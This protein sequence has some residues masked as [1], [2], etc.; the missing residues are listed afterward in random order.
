MWE[1]ELTLGSCHVLCRRATSALGWCC[2]P[3]SSGRCPPSC[4]PRPPRP[5]RATWSCPRRPCRG[6]RRPGVEKAPGVASSTAPPDSLETHSLLSSHVT[7][8]PQL[9]IHLS[10]SGLFLPIL[11]TY[12][13]LFNPLP[14][15]TSQVAAQ[16]VRPG[17]QVVRVK[18]E[19]GWEEVGHRPQTHTE[20]RRLCAPPGGELGNLT[21]TSV[22][23][24]CCTTAK[25]RRTQQT[26]KEK[27]TQ[28]RI[29]LKRKET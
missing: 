22:D 23:E 26:H 3:W 16:L 10:K 14:S 18:R 29:N 24:M 2:P 7:Q 4:P 6:W 15:P 25:N 20:E 27:K 5:P 13:P 21:H 11:P 1:E 9:L 19:V 8:I 28:E 12:V 17:G